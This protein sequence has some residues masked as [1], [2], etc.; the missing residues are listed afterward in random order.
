MTP[1]RWNQLKPV[2]HGALEQP[3][4]RRRAWL[5]EACADDASLVRDAE[6]LLD[7]YDTAGDFLEQPAP[8]PEGATLGVYRIRR[9]LGRGGM[10]VVYLAKDN[11]GR[12]VAIKTLPPVLAAN[13]TLR[14]RLRREAAAA[15]S[16]DHPS[17]ATVHLLDEIDGH[18]VIVSEYVHGET[19]RTVLSRGSIEPQRAHAMA[20]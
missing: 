19:L 6:A 9:E 20:V 15:A 2:F 1:E 17:V 13:P 18:L 10:G 14:E 7:A 8:L 11:L 5:R 4:D 16:I 3:A 12:D